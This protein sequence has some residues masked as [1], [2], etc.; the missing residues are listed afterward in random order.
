M[1]HC[2]LGWG[3]EKDGW[4]IYGLFDTAHKSIIPRDPE[5]RNILS[6][7]IKDYSYEVQMFAPYR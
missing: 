4:Y 2:N 6:V 3:G 7:G 1:V 5:P